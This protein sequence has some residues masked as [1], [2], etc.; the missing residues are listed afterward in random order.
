MWLN[1]EK[2]AG[3]DVAYDC[4][5]GIPGQETHEKAKKQENPECTQRPHDCL[6]TNT[7]TPQ[8]VL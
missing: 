4:D 6:S 2:Q 7:L 5:K 1:H 3:C 8:M